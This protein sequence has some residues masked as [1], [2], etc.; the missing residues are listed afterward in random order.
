MDSIYLFYFY[1]LMHKV[2]FRLFIF[3][4]LLT[5]LLNFAC[6]DQN[7]SEVVF[8]KN[9]MEITSPYIFESASNTSAA[10]FHI[11]NKTSVSEV[12]MSVESNSGT[13]MLHETITN[14]GMVQMRHM[15]GG[16][17]IASKSHLHLEPG[18]FH[19]MLNNLPSNLSV[20]D[21]IELIL[22]FKN[23]GQLTIEVPVIKSSEHA[24]HTH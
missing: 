16:I 21:K 19:V 6:A 20:G 22:E 11:N 4:L 3:A 17:E 8:E 13:A 14:D 7:S 1:K 9:G 10:Y 12:L 5:I 15:V 23:S 2:L 24:G 18:S